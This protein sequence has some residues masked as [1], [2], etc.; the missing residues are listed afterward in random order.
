M[1]LKT[2]MIVGCLVG[3][4]VAGSIQT[5]VQTPPVLAKSVSEQAVTLNQ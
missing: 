3:I 5:I 4:M 1:I 2:Q